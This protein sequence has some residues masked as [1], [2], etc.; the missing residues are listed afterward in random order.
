[1]GSYNRFAKFS[2]AAEAAGRRD[3]EWREE[4]FRRALRALPRPQ[5]RIEVRIHPSAFAGRIFDRADIAELLPAPR[6]PTLH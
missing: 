6:Q 4:E 5:E 2:P 1:M 3:E